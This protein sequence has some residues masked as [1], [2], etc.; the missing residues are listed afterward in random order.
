MPM[1]RVHRDLSEWLQSCHE[2]LGQALVSRGEARVMELC[3]RLADS[4]TRMPEIMG[5]VLP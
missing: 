2:E 5:V 3:H 4:A 1:T